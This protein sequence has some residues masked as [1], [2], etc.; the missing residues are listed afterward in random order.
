MTEPIADLLAER[1]RLQAA[2]ADADS[3]AHRLALAI[4]CLLT[5]AD[6][7]LPV[8][9]RWWDSAHDALRLH[10]ERINQ[11]PA[12]APRKG[13][14]EESS[15][16]SDGLNAAPNAGHQGREASPA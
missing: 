13:G 14:P 16:V 4:E 1:D 5:D 6:M 12:A 9:S 7:P 11:A 3:D 10:R 8:L 15:R 2:L